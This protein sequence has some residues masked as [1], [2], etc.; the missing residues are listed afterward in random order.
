MTEHSGGQG[1]PGELHSPGVTVLIIRLLAV[2]A[3]SG[4]WHSSFSFLLTSKKAPFHIWIDKVQEGGQ[5][6]KNRRLEAAGILGGQPDGKLQ[7]HGEV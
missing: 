4:G 6:G 2:P 1:T 5:V 3:H 7:K